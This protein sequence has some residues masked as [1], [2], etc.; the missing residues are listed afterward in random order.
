[1][2]K[3]ISRNIITK[4]YNELG[5]S[6]YFSRKNKNGVS[7]FYNNLLE[8]PMTMSLLGNIKNKKILDLGCGP[9][10]YAKQLVAKGAKVNG[11]DISSEMIKIAKKECTEACFVQGEIDNLPY[12]NDIFDIVICPLVMDH[13]ENLNPMFKEVKRVLKKNGL[14]IFSGFN[15]V[16]ESTKKK[17]WFFKKFRIIKDYFNEKEYIGIWEEPGKKFPVLHYHKTYQTIIKTILNNGFEI[18][19]YK[20]SFPLKEAKRLFKKE[21]KNTINIPKFCAWKV[22]LKL[23]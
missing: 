23:K 3:K 5:N 18:I 2:N 17:R 9:G 1:M 7:Y 11:I 21:Y 12:K 22:K 15:P 8:M 14:F 20:D 10:I 4:A 13:L 19:D 16:S 6:Y